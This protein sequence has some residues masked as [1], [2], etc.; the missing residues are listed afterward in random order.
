M[1]KHSISIISLA[2]ISTLALLPALGQTAP[3]KSVDDIK[4]AP[5]NSVPLHNSAYDG[6]RPAP[7]PKRDLSGTWYAG[8]DPPP[9]GGAAPG[10]Q[11]T[12]AHEYPAVLPGNNAPPGG[13]PDESKIPRQLPYTPLGLAALKAHKP[14]GMGVRSVPAVL[15]NDPL[16]ICDPP[17]FPRLEL[18][19][20]RALEIAQMPDHI[21]V[22]SQL[23]R[24]W[25]TIWTDGR[26]LPKNPEP[27][28]TGYS[29]GKWI[30][31]YT[32][33]VDTT[34]IDERTWLD[35][36]GRP[37]SR[38]MTVEE[39][40]HRIDNDNMELTLTI[41]DPKMYTQPWQALNKFPLRRLPRGFDIREMYC[42]PSETAQYNKDVGDP[43]VAPEGK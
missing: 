7:A 23:T 40:F 18:Y 34:G 37:H 33:V 19:E 4:V 9:A 39:R 43:S 31:D 30:D 38:E 22:L 15:G 25:R 12:G 5:W 11:A 35:N 27:R 29:V 6:L 1:P 3:P 17:G 20:F 28:W 41:D 8:G 13:E 26:D 24:T 36:A 21:I 2:L 42:V 14:T 32:F 16:D 10:I